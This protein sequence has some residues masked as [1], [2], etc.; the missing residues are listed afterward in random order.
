[1]PLSK[2]TVEFLQRAD[3]L[4]RQT[5]AR[6]KVLLHGAEHPLNFTPAPG[7]AR[8]GVNQTDAQ[9]GAND[10]EV[11]VDEGPSIIDVEFSGQTPSANGLFETGQQRVNVG[12]Q[13]VGAEGNQA[14]VIVDDQTQM[15]GAGLGGNRQERPRRKVG[16]PQLV[17]PGSLEG[18]GGAGNVLAQ[19][20]APAMGIQIVL[21][22]PP[23]NRR[24]LRQARIG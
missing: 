10:L 15:S 17:D 9:V 5:Q 18:L 4:A 12:V 24:D 3:G 20:I 8:L 6:F 1:Q 22:Q 16:A 7:L 21:F 14:G 23:I 13:R 2:L 19:Q 11:L